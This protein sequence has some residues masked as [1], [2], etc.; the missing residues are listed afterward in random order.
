MTAPDGEHDD[1]DPCPPPRD[2]VGKEGRADT[3]GVE[4]ILAERYAKGEISADQLRRRREELRRKR[5]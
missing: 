5:R 2:H 4:E 1:E 3:G